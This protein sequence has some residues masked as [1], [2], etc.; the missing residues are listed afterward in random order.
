M[1]I[2]LLTSRG[3]K[4]VLFSR[5]LVGSVVLVISASGDE[6]FH[7]DGGASVGH[8]LCSLQNWTATC[9]DAA[10]VEAID[11]DE[12]LAESVKD[13]PIDHQGYN[14]VTKFGIVV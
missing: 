6:L 8:V 12:E 10:V 7:G 2:N 13:D 9:G 14:V 5:R 3:V 4:S 1:D 11:A